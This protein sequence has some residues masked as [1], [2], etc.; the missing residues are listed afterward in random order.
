MEILSLFAPVIP[1]IIPKLYDVLSSVEGKTF[2][3][4][5]SVL[6]LLFVDPHFLNLTIYYQCPTVKNYR[7][8][9]INFTRVSFSPHLMLCTVVQHFVEGMTVVKMIV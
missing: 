3:R 1:Y 9:K 7:I 4:N 8:L 2:L 5:V 6:L